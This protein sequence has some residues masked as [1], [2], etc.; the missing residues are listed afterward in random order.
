MATYI[1]SVGEFDQSKE[2]WVA[3]AER[4]EQYFTANDIAYPAKQRAVLLSACGATTYQLI[5]NLVAP[6]A[7]QQTS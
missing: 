1:G 4:M 6:V 3:Y 7:T 2:T 5:R